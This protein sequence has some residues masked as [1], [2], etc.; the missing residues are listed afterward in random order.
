MIL[1]F[2]G[3][4]GGTA[5]TAAAATA[6]AAAAAGRRAL[7]ASIGPSHSVGS[8]AGVGP[9]SAPQ[10]LAPGLDLW[11]LDALEDL[12]AAWGA[13]RGQPSGTPAS[14][15]NSEEL[16]IIPGSDLFLAVARLRRL[17][18]S[19]DLICVDAGHHDGLL[20]ALG[21]PD[22]F[23][24]ALR[25]LLGLDRDP[26][27]SSAS[28]ARAM[29]PSALIPFEWIG[30]VQQ[31]RVQLERLRD[32]TVA[33]DQSRVRYVLRPDR[34]GLEEAAVAL[35][36]L[37]LFGLAV[38]QIIVGPL[39]PA[40]N[41]ALG[42][43]LA[44]QRQVLAD[45]AQTW[46]GLPLRRLDAAATPGGAA[47]LAAIGAALYADGGLLPGPQPA[48][49]LRLAGPTE[50]RVEIDLPGLRR[51]A[52]GLTLSGDELIVRAGPYRRHILMPEGLRGGVAIRAG[53]Q[54]DTLVI[55]PRQANA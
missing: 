52:L 24:W 43:L 27:R 8:L 32:E 46:G 10:S 3:S 51:E 2:V 47:G 15:I 19:Y 5:A 9:S 55:R 29:V 20:R 17:A 40:G 11:A 22:T 7:I 37:Q 36:A 1:I 4:A 53:R 26:G 23:R 16:P 25:L 42:P 39:L 35:P 44:E 45:A 50:P 28:M 21:A 48:P 34:G 33:P 14:A 18:P 49:P 41:V 12:G 13:L 38:E 54:G 30:Q 31:A 6:A